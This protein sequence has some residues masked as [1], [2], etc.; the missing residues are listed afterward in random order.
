MPDFC[1]GWPTIQGH[2][3]LTLVE[4][5]IDA[6][7]AAAAADAV[8][9]AAAV[10]AAAADATA[11]ADAAEAAAIAASVG[12][13]V[14]DLAAVDTG[15]GV[16]SVENTSENDR[17]ITGFSL[18]VTTPA[19][20]G[21]CTVDAGIAA[22]ADGVDDSLLDGQNVGA[23]A[24]VFSAAAKVLWPAGEFLTVSKATEATAGLVGKAVIEYAELA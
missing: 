22:A 18:V 23:A 6:A 3:A 11:K 20:D 24:G 17:L 12:K 2:S 10:A 9:D 16:L 5:A 8:V 14:A 7:I 15:G 13:I 21:S 1:N 19:T 4:T